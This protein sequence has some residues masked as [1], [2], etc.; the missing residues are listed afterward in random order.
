MLSIIITLIAGALS[1]ILHAC[2][3]H[4]IW[5]AIR[6]EDEKQAATRELSVFPSRTHGIMA[7]VGIFFFGVMAGL[8]VY[9][10]YSFELSEGEAGII[11]IGCLLFAIFCLLS[12]Y[13]VFRTCRWRLTVS[14]S[15]LY[16]SPS[17]G[18]EKSWRIRDICAVRETDRFVFLYSGT[19][20]I[21]SIESSY[22]GCDRLCARLRTEGIP[23][24]AMS[25]FLALLRGR[26][27]KS[28]SS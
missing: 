24:K 17:F 16:Y 11:S 5:K 21:V 18:A 26:R 19:K 6:R 10:L 13:V 2:I 15:F 27:L 20:R 25:P 23:F 12:V 9:V 4:F 3:G 22:V 1:M 28:G 8:S 14:G 7:F